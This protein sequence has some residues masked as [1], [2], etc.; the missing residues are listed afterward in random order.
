MPIRSSS[1][2]SA[3]RLGNMSWRASCPLGSF[4]PN[5]EHRY[6]F[7]ATLDSGVSDFYQGKGTVVEFIWSATSA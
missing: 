7:V 2:Y 5:E 3:T 1:L 4:A 6:E